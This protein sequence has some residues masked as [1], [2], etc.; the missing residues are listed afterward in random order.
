MDKLADVIVETITEL[1]GTDKLSL[2][3]YLGLIILCILLFKEFKGKMNE[4]VKN[5]NEQLDIA[6][7]S[8]L[9]LKF[10]M[11]FFKGSQKSN[12]DLTNLRNKLIDAFPFLTFRLSEKLQ[13]IKQFSDNENIDNLI[14]ELEKEINGL[15]HS[16]NSSV[17][18]LNTHNIL[19]NI[20][21]NYRTR[22]YSIFMSVTMTLIALLFIIFVGFIYWALSNIDSVFEKYYLL[23][24][25]INL[26][27]FLF[28]FVL[29]ASLFQENKLKGNINSWFFIIGNPILSVFIISL[30]SSFIFLPSIHFLLLILGFMILKKY[31]K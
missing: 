20:I 3:F 1:F 8:L 15:K 30:Y 4:E 23:Q 13:Q 25:L 22:F 27:I 28:Y 6:L 7:R 26:I 2:L 14:V 19:D 18:E 11:I 5:K 21:Y 24:M 9:D 17:V 16:Q 10:E 12:D 29:V 31:L